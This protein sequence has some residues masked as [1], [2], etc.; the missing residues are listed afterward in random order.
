MWIKLESAVKSGGFLPDRSRTEIVVSKNVPNDP[1]NSNNWG[2]HQRVKKTVFH[3]F[4]RLKS[5][6]LR[7]SLFCLVFQNSLLWKHL[8]ENLNFVT[9][10]DFSMRVWPERPDPDHT[11][12]Q[13]SKV[14]KLKK[15]LWVLQKHLKFNQSW[16]PLTT[17]TFF[18]FSFLIRFCI[19]AP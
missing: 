14:H 16:P 12:V 4:F 18:H 6:W 1:M 9:N 15:C 13:N 17:T 19:F 7:S 10:P 11:P 3:Q 8:H 2:F 5:F